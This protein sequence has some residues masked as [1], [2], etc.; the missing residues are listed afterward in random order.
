M[1]MGLWRLKVLYGKGFAGTVSCS[2]VRGR[3]PCYKEEGIQPFDLRIQGNES[4]F[5]TVAHT[6]TES[7]TGDY[8]VHC[9]R[10]LYVSLEPGSSG[11]IISQPVPVQDTKTPAGQTGLP[12][13]HQRTLPGGLPLPWLLCPAEFRHTMCSSKYILLKAQ[14]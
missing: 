7:G 12:D 9:P 6:C 10:G 3:P 11:N 8:I 5:W 13:Y 2:A 4:P 14:V 1:S